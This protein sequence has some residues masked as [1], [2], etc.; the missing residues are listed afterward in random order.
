MRKIII[1]TAATM[2]L[3]WACNKAIEEPEPEL[4]CFTMQQ[5]TTE[6]SMVD[7]LDSLNTSLYRRLSESEAKLRAIKNKGVEARTATYPI[8]E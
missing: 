4:S 1:L 8:Y 2:L 3:I 6:D 7:V 5:T